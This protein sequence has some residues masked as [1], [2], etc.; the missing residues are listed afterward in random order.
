M[1]AAF[2]AVKRTTMRTNRV[3]VA[4]ASIAIVLLLS[5]F[6]PG[7][8]RIDELNA[9]SGQSVLVRMNRFTGR[10]EVFSRFRGWEVRDPGSA[11]EPPL[12]L[13][14]AGVALLAVFWAGYSIGRRTQP[15][16]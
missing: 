9:G 7:P 10:T 14:M 5:F 1:K 2:E 8:Y 15:P 4:F 13:S 12:L 16:A 3:A 6:W 11:M